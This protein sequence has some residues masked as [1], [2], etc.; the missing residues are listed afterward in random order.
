MRAL[1][2]GLV[3]PDVVV[4]LLDNSCSCTKTIRNTPQFGLDFWD[5][6]LNFVLVEDPPC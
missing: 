3:H 4:V 2:P 6:Q 5:V 1:D